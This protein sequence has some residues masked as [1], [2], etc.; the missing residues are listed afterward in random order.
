MTLLQID[1]GIDT[2]PVYDYFRIDFDERRESH[3]VIQQRL[4]LENLPK[5]REK[6]R[7]ICD[8]RAVPIETSGRRSAVWGQPRL[9]SYW[10][11]RLRARRERR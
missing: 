10:K 5:V 7:E 9:T 11:L 2:G 1:R 8:G 4:L 6:L 3:V